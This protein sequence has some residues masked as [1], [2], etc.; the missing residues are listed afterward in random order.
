MTKEEKQKAYAD[1]LKA[2]QA[3]VDY[4]TINGYAIR[5]RR[6]KPLHGK[7]EIDIIASKGK[8]MAFV[9]VKAR[10]SGIDEAISAVDNKKIR[11]MAFGADKYLNMQPYWY[12][13]RFDIIAI[14]LSQT[15]P[16]IQHIP[17]AFL[18]PLITK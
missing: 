18:A 14:D 8:I 13:Y 6:W 17:D 1:G 11:A 12:E 16:E 5:E 3:A 2:E 15:P 7:G 10:Q 4:L 9:E